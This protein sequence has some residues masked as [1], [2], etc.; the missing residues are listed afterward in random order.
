LLVIYLLR[1]YETIGTES[2]IR[3]QP[4][5]GDLVL[6]ALG[7]HFPGSKDPDAPKNLVSYRLNRVAQ[8]ELLPDLDDEDSGDD[9]GLDD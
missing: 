4:Y 9:V 1:G 2:D 6:P 5:R 8:K 7:L 3:E